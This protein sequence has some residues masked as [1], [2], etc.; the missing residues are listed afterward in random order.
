M[1]VVFGLWVLLFV[2]SA[3]G[4]L[5]SAAQTLKHKKRYVLLKDPGVLLKDCSLTRLCLEGFLLWFQLAGN[6]AA[7]PLT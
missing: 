7:H 6:T 4:Q 5:S 1:H 3:F 2:L